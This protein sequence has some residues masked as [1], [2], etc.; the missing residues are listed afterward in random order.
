M[1]TFAAVVL[2]GLVASTALAGSL[3]PPPTGCNI[4]D[5]LHRYVASDR[6]LPSLNTWLCVLGLVRDRVVSTTESEVVC[7][8]VTVDPATRTAVTLTLS[9]TLIGTEVIPLQITDTSSPPRLVADGL[10]ATT[11]TQI[12]ASVF[13]RDPDS[14]RTGRLCAHIVRP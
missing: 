13:N 11:G 7:Q 9:H 2:L 4:N 5:V 6:V 1:K 10:I 8:A 3:D 12:T 14:A